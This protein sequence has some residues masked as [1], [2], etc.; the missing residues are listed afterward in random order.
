MNPNAPLPADY[1]IWLASLKSR[2]QGARMR[3]LLSANAEQIRL[4][5]DIGHEI[6]ARQR[7]H[8]WGTK[9]IAQLSADLRAA[10]PE[11]K[12]LSATN[13]KYMRFFAEHC[14]NRRFV[15]ESPVAPIG[16]QTADQLDTQHDTAATLTDQ[17]PWFHIVILLTKLSDPALR[18]WYA[19]QAIQHGW[20]REVLTVQI[21]NQLYLTFRTICQMASDQFP[22]PEISPSVQLTAL[23]EALAQ[24]FTLGWSHYVELLTLADDGMG[25]AL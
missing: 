22:S 9:V 4:Y 8:G 5:H 13:L 2:I 1:G 12:G 3:A 18:E 7:Q 16:Q 20:S 19:Q 24:R 15:T 6:L 17:L 23:H 10:F 11:M 25:V 21:T 14:P